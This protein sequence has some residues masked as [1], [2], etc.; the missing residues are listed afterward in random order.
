MHVHVYMTAIYFKED[1]K[2]NTAVSILESGDFVNLINIYTGSQMYSGCS[3]QRR[4]CTYN[5][6]YIFCHFRNHKVPIPL[7]RKKKSN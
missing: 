3:K 5:V 6:Q 4:Q 1:F 2:V 7:G